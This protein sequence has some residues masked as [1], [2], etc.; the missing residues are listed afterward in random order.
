MANRRCFRGYA[1]C[2]D[3]PRWGVSSK[4]GSSGNDCCCEACEAGLDTMLGSGPGSGSDGSALPRSEENGVFSGNAGE[5]TRDGEDGGVVKL[6]RDS[7]RGLDG[8]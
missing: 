8:E 2:R 4:A 7:G 6:S 5:S 1:E 3:L